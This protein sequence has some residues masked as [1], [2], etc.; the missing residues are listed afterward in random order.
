MFPL[1]DRIRKDIDATVRAACSISSIVNV[2]DIASD[3]QRRNWDQNVAIEDLQ[4][5]VMQVAAM[6]GA[7]IAFGAEMRMNGHANLLSPGQE[8]PMW[9]A[10]APVSD[11]KD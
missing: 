3:V 10:A 4:A 8:S 11:K 9:H 6:L 2:N 7:V 1:S 5:R